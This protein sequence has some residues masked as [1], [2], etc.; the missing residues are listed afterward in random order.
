MEY[1][2]TCTLERCPDI[3]IGIST[4]IL[5]IST[6]SRYIR[7]SNGIVL[8]SAHESSDSES[9]VDQFSRIIIAVN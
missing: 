5:I 3:K 9:S 4:D 2:L 8:V 7:W 1:N 6:I